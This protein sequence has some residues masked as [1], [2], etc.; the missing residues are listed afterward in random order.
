MQIAYAYKHVKCFVFPAGMIVADSHMAMVLP[1]NISSRIEEFIAG[2]RTFPFIGRNELVCLM[3]LYGK[4]G[5]VS[6]EEIQ[7]V[8]GFAQRTVLQLGQEIDNYTNTSASKLDPE[9]IRSRYINRELQLTVEKKPDRI[10]G[11][12]TIISD[13]FAQHIAYYKQEYFFELYGPL[14]DLELTSDIRSVLACRMVMTCYNRNGLHE[15]G[16][17]HPLIPVYV[18]F[19]DQ[20]GAKP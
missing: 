12:P 4:S 2:K 3:Y 19:R 8:N 18:W 1:D 9:Y 5:K 16:L 15:T 14:K 20:A 17:S 6:V 13:C 10:G 7:V 11:D